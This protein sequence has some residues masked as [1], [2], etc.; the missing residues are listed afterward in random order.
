MKL[1]YNK[2]ELQLISDGLEDTLIRLKSGQIK[3]DYETYT[4][5]VLVLKGKI[6]RDLEGSQKD[7]I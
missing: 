2:E 7:E 4:S 5:R 6:S 1:E 3:E